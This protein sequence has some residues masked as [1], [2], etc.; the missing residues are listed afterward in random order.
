[1]MARGAVAGGMIFTELKVKG[2]YRIELERIEDE[3]GF[4]ARTWS[5][6]EFAE[7]GL[8]PHLAQCSMSY[9][10]KKGTLRGLH[11]QVAPHQ[12]AKLVQCT[13]GAIYDVVLD[14]RPA[15]PSDRR[16]DAARLTAASHR[17]LYIPEGCAHGFQ[18]LED[19]TEVFYQISHEYH[20]ESGRV[21]RWDDPAFGIEWPLRPTVMSQRDREA[22]A[23]SPVEKQP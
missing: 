7:R 5:A 19:D 1:M 3:R 22:G 12:E 20:A 14:L 9:N 10:K 2:A 17:M 16:W 6:Q 8:N 11:Y 13:R 23:L 18:T 4:F 15:S 21:V